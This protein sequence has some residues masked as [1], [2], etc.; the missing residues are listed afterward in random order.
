M[1]GSEGSSPIRSGSARAFEAAYREHAPGLL[2]V[3][4]SVLHDDAQAQDVVHDV[5]LRL[6]CDPTRFDARRGPLGHFLRMSA[7]SRAV[8]VWREAQVAVRAGDRMRALAACEEGRVDERP[9]VACERRVS[10][11]VVRL[12]LMRLPDVQRE[13]LVLT[14]WGGMTAEEIAC[15]S[16]TPLGTVKSRIRLGLLKLHEACAGD[17]AGDGVRVA[18]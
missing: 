12:A 8:D 14:F 13:A 10:G 16:G 17:L 11:R 7:R 1:D 4:H 9:A 5:F 15:G 2:A 18:A 3:A 6:W